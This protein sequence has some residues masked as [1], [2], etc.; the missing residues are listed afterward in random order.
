MQHHKTILKT[1]LI[2]WHYQSIINSYN[3]TVCLL[4]IHGI[5]ERKDNLVGRKSLRL[6][7]DHHSVCSTFSCLFLINHSAWALKIFFLKIPDVNIVELNIKRKWEKMSWH[8][9][10]TVYSEMGENG[11]NSKIFRIFYTIVLFLR[12]RYKKAS[13]TTRHVAFTC[14]WDNKD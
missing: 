7:I 2:Y 11:R 12:P 8:I 6:D 9:N 5:Q 4:F 13:D 3:Y 10:T 14:I 1:I